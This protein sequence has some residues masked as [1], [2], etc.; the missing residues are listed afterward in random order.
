MNGEPLLRSETSRQF[1]WIVTIHPKYQI[2]GYAV[3]LPIFLDY[4]YNV[5][6]PR[7]DAHQKARDIQ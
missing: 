6:S 4:L 7:I 3:N 1:P 5:A 2:Y